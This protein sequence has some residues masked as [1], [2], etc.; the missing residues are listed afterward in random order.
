MLPK[1]YVKSYNERNPQYIYHILSYYN[2]FVKRG[3]R[4]VKMTFMK[5]ATDVLQ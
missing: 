5:W 1:Y 2:L 4:L 3:I